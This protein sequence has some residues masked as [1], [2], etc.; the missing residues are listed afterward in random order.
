MILVFDDQFDHL[1]H[2][3]ILSSVS[4]FPFS[5]HDSLPYMPLSSSLELISRYSQICMLVFAS[6][7]N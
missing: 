5:S 6:D 1:I 3:S 2:A 4:S 7:L